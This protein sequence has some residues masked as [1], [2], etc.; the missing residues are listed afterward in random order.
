MKKLALLS[1]M[2]FLF[3]AHSL[4]AQYY[5]AI[6]L[7]RPGQS[8]NYN[9]VKKMRFQIESGFAYTSDKNIPG[10]ENLEIVKM[11]I[12]QTT[13][14]FGV[15]KTFEVRL[16]G[17]FTY[18]REKILEQKS[19]ISSLEGVSLGAKLRFLESKGIVPDAAVLVNVGL[20]VG[21]KDLVSDK[22]EPGGRF[23][24]S[25]P[26]S[27]AA[28]L[29]YNLGVTYR[30]A[31]FLE[32]FYAMTFKVNFSEQTTAFIEFAANDPENG[33]SV[34]L[35]DFGISILTSRTVMFDIFG[36]KGLNNEAPDWFISVG[37]GIRLPR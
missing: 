4:F 7:D 1:L 13:L 15:T 30:N 8:I 22:V 32:Y 11:Q 23:I 36:G 18:Q 12:A 5:N 20:P 14:R 26:L 9:T 16:G 34:R 2:V 24:A 29:E 21:S 17:Q 27:E 33:P 10:R 6:T 37:G 31:D 28:R 19:S 25:H 35:F 3:G